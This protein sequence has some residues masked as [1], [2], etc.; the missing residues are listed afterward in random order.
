MPNELDN[1]FNSQK[2]QQEKKDEA[3]RKV[4]RVQNTFI[5]SFKKSLDEIIHP[6]MMKILSKLR[7]KHCYALW[8]RGRREKSNPLEH[9]AEFTQPPKIDVKGNFLY[10]HYE[11]YYIAAPEIAEGVAF[12]LTI[13]GNYCT[14]EVCVI[15]EYVKHNHGNPSTSVKKTMEQYQLAQIT[16]E[17]WESITAD[18]MKEMLAIKQQTDEKMPPTND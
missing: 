5:A 6:A 14:Q 8:L 1:F 2:E 17:L 16:T 3:Q 7:D 18:R 10:K 11:N 13:L 12:I 9:V 4:W 15:T